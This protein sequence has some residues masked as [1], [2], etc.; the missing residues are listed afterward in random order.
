VIRAG[1]F[2][3]ASRAGVD[4]SSTGDAD[5]PGNGLDAEVLRGFEMN[6]AWIDSSTFEGSGN[7]GSIRIRAGSLQ[8]AAAQANPF[9][10]S[11]T[12]QQ[13]FVLGG[14]VGT[15]D[16]GEIHVHAD[17]LVS[18]SDRAFIQTETFRNMPGAGGD[19]TLLAQR[20]EVHDGSQIRANARGEGRGGDIRVTADEVLLENDASLGMTGLGAFAHGSG[21]GGWIFVN[22]DSVDVL[23]G[24][25]ISTPT[26][27]EG[28]GGSVKMIA[29]ELRVAGSGA[30]V[31]ATVGSFGT[32][33][34]G[35][36]RLRVR[37]IGVDD[38]GQIATFTFLNSAGG[39]AGDVRADS[40]TI[41]VA[42]GGSIS[43][44]TFAAGFGGQPAGDA[45]RVILETGLLDVS[46][47]GAI[48]SDSRGPG[49]ANL[50]KVEADRVRLTGG[51]VITSNALSTGD[52]ARV[53]VDARRVSIEGAGELVGA[54]D[55]P[56]SFS[57]I[58]SG[59]LFGAPGRIVVNADR[60][61][62][63]G[64]GKIATQNLGPSEEGGSIRIRAD[65]VTV[66]GAYG[67]SSAAASAITSDSAQFLSFPPATGPAGDIT[68]TGRSGA[69][70]VLVVDDGG[71]ISSRTRTTG[72][73]GNVFVEFDKVKIENGS[74]ITVQS[75][76]TA[77]D[78]GDAPGDAGNIE[79][80]GHDLIRVVDSAIIAL[81]AEADGGNIK[82]TSEGIVYLRN[83]LISAAVGG[84]AGSGGN[85]DI[86]PD[87][88]VLDQSTIS[89]SA[90][91]G[92]G[93][94]ITIVSDFF[95][96]TPDSVLT[97]TSELRNDGQIVV[98]SPETAIVSQITALP[99]S[100]LDAAALLRERCAAQRGDVPRGSFV[101]TG[102]DG[103][104]AA[105]D[106]LLS[107]PLGGGEAG[108]DP[109]S[110]IFWRN[111]ETQRVALVAVCRR[112]ETPERESGPPREAS[113]GSPPPFDFIAKR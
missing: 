17:G 9:G 11:I 97:A 89:A 65:R 79:V 92:D 4:S 42:N 41:T 25:E 28:H 78:L 59:G 8:M 85:V 47:R 110:A 6:D 24:A 61:D 27:D 71:E 36:V 107:A 29:D 95:F 76:G 39:N 49:N 23:D 81:A 94:N 74:V 46:N 34:G 10:T 19:V 77:A 101:V 84:G 82:L 93:G 90:I 80:I 109:G 16:T 67:D 91:G 102:R 12:S 52:G 69:R 50:I 55:Q 53:R 43:A 112:E 57:G 7:A 64:G 113:A 100:Y 72:A 5:H 37:D 13:K 18:L 73:G 45:G 38:F 15:G 32:G 44:S 98:D 22:A 75:T 88:V 40:E 86:D 66:A 105:P 111:P 54:G 56:F 35:D 31:F 87:F 20:L 3:M 96:A 70:S 103:I 62:V 33:D 51:G 26:F 106:G 60:L 58:S 2:T 21:D 68:I 99:E 83:A 104:P 63:L 1:E 30:G 48:S 108:A 14:N